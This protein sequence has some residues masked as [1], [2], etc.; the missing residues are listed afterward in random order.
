MNQQLLNNIIQ[1]VVLVIAALATYVLHHQTEIKSAA[2]DNQ[3]AQ[4]TVDAISK[5]AAFAVHELQNGDL[6]NASKRTAAINLV[7]STLKQMGLPTVDNKVIS[8]AVESAVSAM[9][10]AWGQ[11]PS[12]DGQD[13]SAA[14][15][16]VTSASQGQTLAYDPQSQIATD[17]SG[18]AYT[19][20]HLGDKVAPKSATTSGGDADSADPTVYSAD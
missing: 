12:N 18:A 15:K 16:N 5:L 4:T 13:T 2:K 14:K 9:H 19:V 17:S 1:A 10:L 11:Q 20:T 3:L 7:T 6:D 8:G